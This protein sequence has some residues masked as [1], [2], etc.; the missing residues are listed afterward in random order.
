MSS[1]DTP[2]KTIIVIQN[3]T[4]VDAKKLG[5]KDWAGQGQPPETISDGGSGNF[6]QVANTDGSIGGVVYEGVLGYQFIFAWSNKNVVKNQAYT[7]SLNPGD[8]I[9][10]DDIKK[11]LGQSSNTSSDSVSTYSSN[12]GI[13][14]TG[15]SPTFVAQLKG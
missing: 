3:N 1:S 4:G 6:T 9:D 8:K 12:A 15:G 13:D 11:R 10:W 5:Y 7:K 2:V 14:A